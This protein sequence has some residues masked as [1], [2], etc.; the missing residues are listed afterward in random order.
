MS[1]SF[2]TKWTQTFPPPGPINESNLSSQ[3]GKVFV[4]TGGSHGLGYELSKILYGAGG[5]VYIFTRSKERGEE[6]ISQIKAS[7]ESKDANKKL[8]SLVFIQMDLM[9]FESIKNAA[10]EFLQLEGPDGR[11]DVL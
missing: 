2:S 4:V 11:L 8:G 1:V 6:A 5:K 10:R 3:A 7:Y 9:D